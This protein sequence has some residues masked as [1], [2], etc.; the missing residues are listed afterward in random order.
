MSIEIKMPMLSP[1]MTKGLIAN[2]LVEVGDSVVAGDLIVEIETDKVTIEVEA[3][4][5]GVSQ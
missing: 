1:T 4:E 3:N 5:D 2:W